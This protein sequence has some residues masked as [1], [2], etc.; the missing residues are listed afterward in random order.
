MKKR[1]E[2]KEPL[3]DSKA[4]FKL[5]KNENW[6]APESKPKKRTRVVT[7]KDLPPAA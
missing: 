4:T 1:T 6:K 3:K 7:D 2:A 5:I